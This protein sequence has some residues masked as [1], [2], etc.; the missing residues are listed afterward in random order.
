ML[1]KYWLK[2]STLLIVLN[3]CNISGC[4]IY[5]PRPSTVADMHTSS[6]QVYSDND[7][8][9]LFSFPESYLPEKELDSQSIAEEEGAP[10]ED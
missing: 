10:Y 6:Y 8:L 9:N 3:I 4:D 7:S 1:T 5:K 2:S